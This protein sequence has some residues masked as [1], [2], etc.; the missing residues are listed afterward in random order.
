MTFWKVIFWLLAL[1]TLKDAVGLMFS[2]DAAPMDLIALAVGAFL[3]IPYYGYAYQVAIGWKLFWQ[4]S[5]VAVFLLGSYGWI[6]FFNAFLSNPNHISFILLGL[7]I[8]LAL[9]IF[10]PPFKYA[11]KSDNIWLNH[12]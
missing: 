8:G 11:F 5:F 9:L 2:G 10:I 6:L 1:L 12:A 7:G 3:L 4:I